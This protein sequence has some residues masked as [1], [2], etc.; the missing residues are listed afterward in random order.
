M[1]FEV[2]MRHVLKT[3]VLTLAVATALPLTVQAAPDPASEALSACL[4]RSAT[5]EDRTTLIRWAFTVVARHPNVAD[6]SSITDEQRQAVNKATGK[7]LTR[8]ISSDCAAEARSAIATGG[9]ESLTGAFN[10]LGQ[11]ALKDLMSDRSVQSSFGE[12]LN[13]VDQGALLRA[14]M[15]Q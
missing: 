7:L 15:T 10:A 12:L 5:P 1:H 8:L 14:L 11:D 13:Y 3:V 6:L 4:V 2:K 9:Q